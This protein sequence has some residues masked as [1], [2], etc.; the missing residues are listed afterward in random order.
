[1]KCVYKIVNTITDDVYVGSALNFYKRKYYHLY[2]LKNKK[3]HSPILQNSWNKYGCDVF[4]FVVIEEIDKNEDLIIREQYWMDE[5]KP[6]F[7]VAKIAGSPLGVKHTLQSRVNMSNAQKGKSLKER[8]HKDKCECC[9][10][11]SKKGINHFFF[12]KKRSN[13]DKKKVSD[14][15]KEYYKNGGINSRKNKKLKLSTKKKITKKL[16]IPISQYNRNGKFIKNWLGSTDA[17]KKLRINPANI[18]QCCN[19]KIKTSGGYIWS[20][21]DKKPNFDL[22]KKIIPI[23]VI[24]I[25]NNKILEFKCVN[26]AAIKLKLNVANI[27]SC[28]NNKRKTCGGYTW[29]YKIKQNDI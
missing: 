19:G 4:C 18:N 13:E 8:G 6:V 5:L 27:Y 11:K 26:D 17:G 3:H 2:D 10:C 24:C 1:M 21:K 15:L 7:N 14:G 23:P 20:F 12:G 25:K 28:C 16:M 9:F 22:T 29:K